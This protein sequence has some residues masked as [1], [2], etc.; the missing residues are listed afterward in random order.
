M[1]K[2]GLSIYRLLRFQVIAFFG[3][4]LIGYC[5]FR[6]EHIQVIA[7][8]GL[9]V[10]RLER[11]LLCNCPVYSFRSFSVIALSAPRFLALASSASAV[12]KE[13]HVGVRQE[14]VQGHHRPVG[15]N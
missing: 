7:F 1:P 10:F 9:S 12:L 14:L 3:L 8:A 4:S 11:P 6:L 2:S 13:E 5:I 15:V